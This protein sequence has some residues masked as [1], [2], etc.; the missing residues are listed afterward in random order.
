MSI[1]TYA[2]L[3]TAASNWLDRTDLSSR[4][5][6][7]VALFEAQINRRL[8]VRPQTTTSTIT[9]TSGS[10]TLPT[11]YLEWKRVTWTG[12]PTREL[13]YV[14]PS[15]LSA[16]NP[17]SLSDTPTHFTIEGSTIKVA[18]LSDTSLQMLYSQKVPALSDS[19]TT[20]WLLTS[21][22]DAYLFG[23][24]TMSATLTGDAGN[25]QAWN[26]LTQNILGELW[27]LD[28][29]QRGTVVQVA[30]GPTP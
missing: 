25:G 24:L 30:T 28:F 6:E 5:P 20:N 27:G 3:K 23:T 22:P 2:E 17:D 13:S 19:A 16:F 26:A 9:I 10:G 7:F 29:A 12:S 4:V 18:R 8:R 14:T 11:D 15:A 21:H 1:G